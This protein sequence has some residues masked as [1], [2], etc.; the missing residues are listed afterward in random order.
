MMNRENPSVHTR[1]ERTSGKEEPG[2]GVPET[3]R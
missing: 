2:I 1:E 3:I